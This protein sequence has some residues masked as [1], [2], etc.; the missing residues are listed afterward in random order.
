MEL[1]IIILSYKQKG[2]IR[3]SLKGLKFLNIPF[4]Y[5]IIVVDNN[6]G[7]NIKEMISSEFMNVK[8][9][10]AAANRGYAAGNNLGIKEAKGKYVLILNPDVTILGD[11]IT[12]LIE[13]MDSHSHCGIC[14]PK[15]LNADNSL[16]YTCSRFPDWRLPFFRRT[17]LGRTLQGKKWSE[18]YL[19]MDWDHNQDRQVDW[20]FGACLMVRREA[21]D[22]VGLLDERYFL[23]MEDLD[24]CRRFWDKAWEV[25]YVASAEV[26]HYHQRLSAEGNF[27]TSLFSRTARM[28]LASWIK[29]FLKFRKNQKK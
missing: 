29:Y 9:I 20:L 17:F 11:A 24:W 27:F 25:W 1:S 7:D 10:E 4:N 8:L 22:E 15:V 3:Q 19:M 12:K 6:S 14:G 18:D 26:I 16:Q 28:H 13:F 5:E 21:I 2:L 23:Y